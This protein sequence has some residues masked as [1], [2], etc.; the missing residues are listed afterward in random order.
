MSTTMSVTRALTKL[1]TLDRKINNAIVQFDGICVV[2]GKN[3][4]PFG[5]TKLE[6]YEKSVRTKYQSLTDLILF[7][8]KLKSAIVKSNATTT[9][10]IADQNMTVAEAI[11]RKT[12]IQYRKSLVTE[13]RRSF[14][15]ANNEFERDDRKCQER[16]DSMIV[17]NLGKEATPKSDEYEAIAKPFLERNQPRLLDPIKMQDETDK[18]DNEIISFE[19]EVDVVLSESN[20]KTDITIDSVDPIN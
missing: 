20:A 10:T 4:L 9:V 12:S 2:K 15:A 17:Q 18:L 1:K 16:L 5:V 13:L 6:D 14:S 3:G 7:R 8:D 11:E 19:E